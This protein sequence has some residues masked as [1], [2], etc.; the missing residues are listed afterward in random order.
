M[1][2]TPI[3]ET[4]LAGSCL[5]GLVKYSITGK[6]LRFLHCHCSRC[7][8]VSGT[9]HASNILMKSEG[10]KWLAN[11]DQVNHFRLPEA[12]SYTSVFCKNC[13]SSLPW[14]VPGQPLTL[15]PAGSLDTEPPLLP[16]GRIFW[17]SRASWSCDDRALPCF[18]GMP[19][20]EELGG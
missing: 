12:D 3:E 10:C 5:C 17:S 8:K 13:G 4:T 9:G 14:Q 15:V 6:A 20:R 18:D 16:Q 11:A 19:T 1:S 7:R 2:P